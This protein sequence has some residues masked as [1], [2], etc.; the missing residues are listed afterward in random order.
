M[1]L[2]D[3]KCESC[4]EVWEELRRDQSDPETCKQCGAEKPKRLVSTSTGFILKGNGW[5]ASDY[6]GK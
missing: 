5:F 4:G 6:K 3:Y 2:R 1:P